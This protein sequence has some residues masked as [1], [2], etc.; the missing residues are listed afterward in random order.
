MLRNL[1]ALFHFLC[2]PEKR[3][4]EVEEEGNDSGPLDALGPKGKKKARA[5]TSCSH[6]KGP[7]RLFQQLDTLLQVG[8]GD[9]DHWTASAMQEVSAITSTTATGAKPL[10]VLINPPA[11]SAHS[12][13]TVQQSLVQR[14]RSAASSLTA[15]AM[16][17]YESSV[18]EIQHCVEQANQAL[19]A[20]SRL[21]R[22]ESIN[23]DETHFL[24][25]PG[26]KQ[27][28]VSFSPANSRTPSV[29]SGGS[30]LSREVTGKE[31]PLLHQRMKH[32]IAIMEKLVPH[33]GLFLLLTQ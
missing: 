4:K 30:S 14:F 20:S 33:G 12:S 32:L 5:G 10:S 13:T 16:K 19:I 23:I 11:M 31:V 18:H 9:S 2:A 29:G 27:S 3:S 24:K 26:V 22:Q 6:L 1:K 17:L 21:D 8:H 15:S 25:S 7:H 28:P